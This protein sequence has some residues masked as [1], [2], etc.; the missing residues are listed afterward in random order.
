MLLHVQVYVDTLVK[1][2]YDNWDQVV[3]YD[4]KSLLSTK[5]NKS[6]GASGNELHIESIDYSLDHQLPLL[7]PGSVPSEQQ[8]NPGI[9]AEGKNG[10][11]L[12]K[13]KFM[14]PL[15]Y[16]PSSSLLCCG[17]FGLSIILSSL[18]NF[19]RQISDG[20][21]ETSSLYFVIKLKFKL[22][23]KKILILCMDSSILF[24]VFFCTQ[25]DI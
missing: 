22:K 18:F 21:D 7:L 13:K 17:C 23:K 11:L 9:T 25:A 12:K 4:G 10:C 16:A 5:Q 8:I 6:P 3:E 1:K 2:A 15:V 24:L 14:D 20:N 19:Q